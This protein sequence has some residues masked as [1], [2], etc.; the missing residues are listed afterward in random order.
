MTF[1]QTSNSI[2]GWV[3]IF[4]LCS[5]LFLP[6]CKKPE[7]KIYVQ[8][9]FKEWTLFQYGSYWIY[10]NEKN[11]RSDSAYLYSYPLTLFYKLPGDGKLYELII[12]QVLNIG[13]F[14]LAAEKDKSIMLILGKVRGY[15]LAS[16]VT[17]GLSDQ[18]STTCW[19][20]NRYDSLVVNNHMFLDVIHTRDTFSNSI[21]DYYFAKKIGLIK[22][23]I[24]NEL[25]DTTWSL[26]RYHVVQ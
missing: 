24:K 13:E 20:V 17:S 4:C 5:I 9:A 21:T 12:F 11:S 8:D 19:V 18:V 22:Y 7:E 25:G 23:A 1:K 10:L 26:L 15:A 2:K 3:R 16:L 14:K 6:D